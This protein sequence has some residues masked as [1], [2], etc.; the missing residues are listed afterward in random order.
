MRLKS[1]IKEAKKLRKQLA[2]PEEDFW[3][4]DPETDK[5]VAPETAKPNLTPKKCPPGEVFNNTQRK[6]I[7]LRGGF[8]R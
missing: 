8:G 3:H 6:C 4:P 2:E 5:K 7:S 1:L